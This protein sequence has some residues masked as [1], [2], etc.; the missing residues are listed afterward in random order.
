MAEFVAVTDQ[1]HPESKSSESPEKADDCSLSKKNPDDL[2]N[3][4]PER[5]H[6][7]DFTTLLHR[8]SDERAHDSERR[9]DYD[10]K[11]KKK[12]YGALEPY[13]FEKLA[14]HVDPCLR[15]PGRRA[16]L[17]NRSSYHLGDV[18]GGGAYGDAVQRDHQA[19]PHLS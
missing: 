10:E 5:F 12:H 4:R 13:R 8:H 9:D 17:F 16:S 2:R 3:V 15:V 19:V 6:N 7:S 18:R 14:V 1:R 11:Q